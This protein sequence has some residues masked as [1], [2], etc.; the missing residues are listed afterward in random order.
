[1]RGAPDRLGK[2]VLS[3]QSIDRTAVLRNTCGRPIALFL[4]LLLPSAAAA[5]DRIILRNLQL[6]ADRTVVAVDADGAQLDA[7]RSDGSDRITWDEIERGRVSAELQESFDRFKT[8]L[9]PPLYKLRLRLRTGDYLGLREPAESLYSEFRDRRSQTA[10]LV[11]QSL[12]WSRLAH[13]KREDAVEPFL[14]CVVLIRSGAADETRLPGARRLQIPADGGF[15]GDL[16][17]VWLDD[18]A[19]K[20]V[21]PAVQ[22]LVKEMPMPR[23]PEAYLYYASLASHARRFDEAIKVLSAVEGS[24]PVSSARQLLSAQ[25]EIQ[26]QAPGQEASQL[27]KTADGP[28]TLL[29]SLAGYWRGMDLLASSDLDRQRDG[30]L[31]LLAIPAN[32]GEQAEMAAA[33]LHVSAAALESMGNAEGARA[34]RR[35][36]QTR[37]AATA[38]GA[39]SLAGMRAG[40]PANASSGR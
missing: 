25:I 24:E 13:G 4:I 19:V 12:M 23:P 39:Q 31:S 38:F 7:P 16:P 3:A 2:L 8:E 10:Y 36:L 37:Y 40:A 34:L 5:R 1:M 15:C 17:P 32:D 26:R 30:L 35:E 21:L 27:A 29:S 33:A 9:G 28:L 14:R 22:Q 6:V 20:E 11:C 18:Q